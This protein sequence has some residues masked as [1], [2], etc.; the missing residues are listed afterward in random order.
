MYASGL[1]KNSNVITQN[2]FALFVRWIKLSES[3]LATNIKK[4]KVEG[5]FS[6]CFFPLGTWKRTL[7]FSALSKHNSPSDPSILPNQTVIWHFFESLDIRCKSI[8]YIN[9]ISNNIIRK[10]K[11]SFKIR[12]LQVADLDYNQHMAKKIN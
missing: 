4:R 9:T 7:V 8:Q 11:K 5:K 10:K 1:N 12:H 6:Q 3:H 2:S